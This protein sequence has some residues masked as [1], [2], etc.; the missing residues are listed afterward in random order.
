MQAR[1]VLM[2]PKHLLQ[3]HQLVFLNIVQHRRGTFKILHIQLFHT[4]AAVAVV[5]LGKDGLLPV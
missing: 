5:D 2:L 3:H 1:H 4:A